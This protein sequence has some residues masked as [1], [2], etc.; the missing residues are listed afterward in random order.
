MDWGEDQSECNK[1]YYTSLACLLCYGSRAFPSLAGLCFGTEKTVS[2]AS[3]EKK[4]PP[5]WVSI[6]QHF[7]ENS[8]KAKND[9]FFS[10]FLHVFSD[11]EFTSAKFPFYHRNHHMCAL[12]GLWCASQHTKNNL[13]KT[14]TR[15]TVA[16]LFS[17]VDDDVVLLLLLLLLLP[18]RAK[19]IHCWVGRSFR[20]FVGKGR[21]FGLGWALMTSSLSP[22]PFFPLPQCCWLL[23]NI[24]DNN[25]NTKRVKTRKAGSKYIQYIC[26]WVSL[27]GPKIYQLPWL[28]PNDMAI[29]PPFFPCFQRILV[30]LSLRFPA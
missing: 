9:H 6:L 30:S 14:P 28:P 25:T 12:Y 7:S 18:G 3:K 23:L 10:F 20:W 13:E 19:V 17:I 11:V 4:A 22:F 1:F 5:K 21:K 2:D 26:M 16:A 15:C 27:R 29:R 8:K 24:P